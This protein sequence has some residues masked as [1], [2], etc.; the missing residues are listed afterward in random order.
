MIDEYGSLIARWMDNGLVFLVST[1]H[2][3]GKEKLRVRKRP[4]ITS[5]NKKKMLRKFGEPKVKRGLQYDDGATFQT[6]KVIGNSHVH[7][8]SKKNLFSN[9]FSI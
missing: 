5:K 4:R 9:A 2:R 1:V 8:I 3:V 7:V 6:F